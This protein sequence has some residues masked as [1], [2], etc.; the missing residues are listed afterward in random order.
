[1]DGK[2]QQLPTWRAQDY[3]YIVEQLHDI[4]KHPECVLS[5]FDL[6]KSRAQ[7]K[8]TTRSHLFILIS[9]KCEA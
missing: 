5:K 6:D 8:I 9:L 2:K 1:M 3:L 7:I 4:A